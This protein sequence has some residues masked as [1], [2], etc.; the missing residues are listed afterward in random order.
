MVDSSRVRPF[1]DGLLEY[2]HKAVEKDGLTSTELV[3]SLCYATA[4]T[5]VGVSNSRADLADNLA[6][7]GGL[8]KLQVVNIY[9]HNGTT[10][11]D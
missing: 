7:F 5:L 9:A 4:T 3:V 10:L 8:L 1:L 11:D 6:S 2:C